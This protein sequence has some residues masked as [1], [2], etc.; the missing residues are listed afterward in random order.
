[1]LKKTECET[2]F[3]P[4]LAQEIMLL[5][6]RPE[7]ALMAQGMIHKAKRTYVDSHHTRKISQMHSSDK[8]RDG[9]WSTYVNIDGK[10]RMIEKQTEE[11][12]Y[13]YLYDFYKAQED[14]AKTFQDVFDL[15]MEHKKELARS[16]QTI[17]EDTRYFGFVDPKI[18]SKPIA[19]I[20]EDELR[21]WLIKQYM[22]TMPKQQALKKM[23]QV[24]N[25]TF[26]YGHDKNLCHGNPAEFLHYDDYASKC[27]LTTR[28][29]EE[30]SFSDEEI[31]ILKENALKD[32]S[33]PHNIA[34]LISMETGLRAGELAALRWKDVR[35]NRLHVHSQ[36]IRD[37][38]KE[39]QSFEMVG[40]TK[41]ERRKPKGGRFVPITPECQKAL[42]YAQNLPGES[43]FILHN[44]AGRAIIKDS[45]EQFLRRKCHSLGIDT[46]HNHAFRVAFNARLIA[47]NLDGNERCYV[48]G[49]TMQ[50][51]ERCY[52]FSD[53]RKL[54]SITKKMLKN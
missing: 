38:S 28:S 49:H 12:I 44:K 15:L 34:M 29:N 23:L 27:D 4:S 17:A 20:T 26:R 43:E 3:S 32:L 18:K 9:K 21:H 11:D 51:N 30:H 10:R 25:Q 45:Y 40:Y 19:D 7:N 46:T 53:E 8:Y 33:N 2:A 54:D 36:Q 47:D 50:T 42:E 1:M 39:H 5:L 13:N 31:A 16:D 52:S 24:L 41:N 14:A 37:R 22:P 48:L 35:K 6:S